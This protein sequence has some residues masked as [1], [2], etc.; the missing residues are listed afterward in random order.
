[1]V[2][3]ENVYIRNKLSYISPVS[4]TLR[5]IELFRSVGI[6]EKNGS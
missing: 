1:M 6:P 4:R 2:Q 5:D 3:K